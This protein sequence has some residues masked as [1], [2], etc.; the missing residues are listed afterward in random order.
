MNKYYAF[1]NIDCY[2]KEN[3]FPNKNNGYFIDIGAHDGISGNNTYYFEKEGWDGICFEPIPKVFEKLKQ[4]RKCK[5]INKALS[6]NKSIEQ[7][8]LIKGHSEQLSGLVNQYSEDHI[9]R[10]NREIEEYNQEFEYI[11]V[12]CSTFL[13]EIENTNIDL[14][15]IDTEGSEFSI[16]QTIDFNKYNINI[17]VIEYNYNNQSLINLVNNNGFEIVKIIGCDLI[18]KNTNY[19]Y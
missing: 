19:V 16:L 8:F 18:L 13:N 3:F 10:I 11:G 17:M 15:S 2:I 14:L 12:E 7:F 6:Y 1:N 9:I 4:N 5:L